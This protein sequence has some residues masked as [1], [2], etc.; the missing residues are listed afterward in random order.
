MDQQLISNHIK[1]F[2]VDDTAREILRSVSL[3]KWS[4]PP[5]HFFLE[6]WR[7]I[8]P[9]YLLAWL[10]RPTPEG[11]SRPHPDIVPRLVEYFGKASTGNQWLADGVLSELSQ[12]ADEYVRDELI[13]SLRAKLPEEL[14][15][16]LLPS[17]EGCDVFR[18]LARADHR[19]LQHHVPRGIAIETP[20][21][22]AVQLFPDRRDTNRCIQNLRALASRPDFGDY[23]LWLLQEVGLLKRVATPEMLLENLPSLHEQ[24]FGSDAHTR[25]RFHLGLA[26]DLA[27][28]P[29]FGKVVTTRIL[30]AAKRGVPWG[31]LWWEIPESLRDDVALA[32]M[33]TA[34]Y[35]PWAGLAIRRRLVGN[36]FWEA[37]L[38]LLEHPGP[39][40]AEH[41]HFLKGAV[42]AGRKASE[43]KAELDAF[44]PSEVGNWLL[45]EPLPEE[46]DEEFELRLG[47]ALRQ[48]LPAGSE[49]MIAARIAE[50]PLDAGRARRIV[51]MALASGD[52]YRLPKCADIA[53]A[54]GPWE[55]P[56]PRPERATRQ[57]VQAYVALAG[58]MAALSRWFDD[59]VELGDFWGA[60]ELATIDESIRTVERTDGL[61]RLVP[62]DDLGRLIQLQGN[63]PWLVADH[64]VLA[65]SAT[66]EYS[67]QHW[68]RLGHVPA[69]FLPVL[70]AKLIS[71]DNADVAEELFRHLK[72][73]NTSASDVI[74]IVLER[75]Q[76]Y[77]V[78]AV[79]AHTLASYLASGKTWEK[80]GRPLV[81][82]VVD[83]RRAESAHWLYTIVSHSAGTEAG[84]TSAIHA[85]VA[86]V[87]IDATEEALAGGDV[88]HARQ[89]LRGL[90]RLTAPPRLFRRVRAL[91]KLPNADQVDALLDANEGLMRRTDGVPGEVVHVGSALF[92]CAGEQAPDDPDDDDEP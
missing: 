15:K 9:G 40:W 77:G 52:F 90:A 11:C 81:K 27:D 21:D 5:E 45:H 56:V 17:A 51:A 34:N 30:E 92:I 65:V 2:G 36:A 86:N 57:T 85:T 68:R 78:K 76:L 31:R 67:D 84:I 50:L 72:Q 63:H 28:A 12:I 37:L 73:A 88:K 69:Y 87:I 16:Q 83:D 74:N 38:A 41:K 89:L 59:L 55:Q 82:L 22:H 91:K 33:G 23:T 79:Y 54:S 4:G 58:G 7:E 47:V 62:Q 24:E 80:L 43:V 6:H 26:D 71:T 14:W 64:E 70:R 29:T 42:E 19:V 3:D 8:S 75:F 1:A 32:T 60:L 46:A 66:R 35:A 39:T 13:E 61:K 25:I 20:L 10:S 44:M 48:I 53:N 18:S 49:G